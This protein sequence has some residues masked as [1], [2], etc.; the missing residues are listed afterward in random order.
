MTVSFPVN[1]HL[2]A[3]LKIA[4]LERPPVFGICGARS[5]TGTDKRTEFLDEQPEWPHYEMIR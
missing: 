2:F 4:T 1:P 5:S 3:V